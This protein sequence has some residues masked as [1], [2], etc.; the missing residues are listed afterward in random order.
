MT[1][2]GA[3]SGGRRIEFVRGG[4]PDD[5]GVE[6]AI[7]L[8]LDALAGDRD[9]PAPAW[10][11]AGVEAAVRGRDVRSPSGLTDRPGTG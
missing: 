9:D 8:A 3:P 7:V 11:R 4:V 5:P 10:W 2:D 6:R 1:G